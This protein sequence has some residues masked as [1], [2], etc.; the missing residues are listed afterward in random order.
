MFQIAELPD[1][2]QDRFLDM[3]KGAL[4]A[5]DA[6]QKKEDEDAEGES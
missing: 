5:L 6:Q 4:M 2:V 3:V 1:S